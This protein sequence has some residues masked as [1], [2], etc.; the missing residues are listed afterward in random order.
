MFREFVYWD[1]LHLDPI[2]IWDKAVR[3]CGIRCVSSILFHGRS[4][5]RRWE[6]CGSYART[7]GG[8][9]PWSSPFF[10]FV[11]VNFV[12]KDAARYTGSWGRESRRVECEGDVMRIGW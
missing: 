3:S 8:S 6:L 9:G 2:C 10:P 12:A 1:G 4:S 7:S 5:R 11:P